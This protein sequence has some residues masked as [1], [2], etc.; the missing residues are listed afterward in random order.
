VIATHVVRAF[1]ARTL[2]PGAVVVSSNHSTENPIQSSPQHSYTDLCRNDRPMSTL[3][4]YQ[5]LAKM[6]KIRYDQGMSAASGGLKKSTLVSGD[7]AVDITTLTGCPATPL[8]VMIRAAHILA[9]E[10]CPVPVPTNSVSEAA[11]A[12]EQIQVDKGVVVRAGGVLIPVGLDLRKKVFA[13]VDVKRRLLSPIGNHR[14][15]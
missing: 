8:V 5:T 11:A 1:G 12:T 2:V 15:V 10:A 4:F 13:S 6:A 7:S 9:Y 3:R 14:V